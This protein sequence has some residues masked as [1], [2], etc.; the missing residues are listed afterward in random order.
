[1]YVYNSALQCTIYILFQF[2]PTPFLV[3]IKTYTYPCIIHHCVVKGS[4]NFIY[5]RM[6]HNAK[7]NSVYSYV[8]VFLEVV[9]FYNI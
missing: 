7:T 8:S 9:N 4:L 5:I 1:M 2:L 3:D 6:P